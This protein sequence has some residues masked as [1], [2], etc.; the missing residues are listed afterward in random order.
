[1]SED[2]MRSNLMVLAHSFASAKGWALSTVSKK[3]HGDQS[4][5]E[6]YISGKGSTRIDTYF[7]MVD[8][9]RAEWPTGAPW[10]QTTEVPKLS[11]TPHKKLPDR[12]ARGK[13]LGK[14]LDKGSGG[15]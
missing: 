11:R 4:F 3:I 14:K 7:L 5:M 10:P 15:A 12:G 8:R 13:F 2:I 9:F 6:R 1:M